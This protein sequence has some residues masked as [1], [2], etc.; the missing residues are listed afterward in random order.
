MVLI[1]L[2]GIKGE[3]GRTTRAYFAGA[4]HGSVRDGVRPEALWS[5]DRLGEAHCRNLTEHSEKP[6]AKIF[7]ELEY[8]FRSLPKTRPK[9]TSTF[10][11]RANF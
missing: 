11:T 8:R 3:G 10:Q 6:A 5:V 9:V 1:R 2:A 7:R 4:R